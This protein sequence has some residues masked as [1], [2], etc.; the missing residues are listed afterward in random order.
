MDSGTRPA[1]KKLT[2]FVEM[3][4]NSRRNISH[5]SEK[6]INH[7]NT[8]KLSCEIGHDLFIFTWNA[9][10]QQAGEL[11]SN[12]AEKRR[13]HTPV[14]RRKTSAECVGTCADC[15]NWTVCTDCG[16]WV[17]WMPKHLIRVATRAGIT[18]SLGPTPTAH[19]H[20]HTVSGLAGVW[21][22]YK[23]PLIILFQ[24][25]LNIILLRS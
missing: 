19:T 18:A 1:L 10:V 3:K 8:A 25:P 20:T 11:N 9:H 5:I 22:G 24:S 12:I 23:H 17:M 4:W 14:R 21:L 15:F 13:I 6:I 7:T 16:L 2:W